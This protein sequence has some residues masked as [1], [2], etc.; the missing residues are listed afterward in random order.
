MIGPCAKQVVTATII[1]PDGTRFVG[2]NFCHAAQP[3]CPRAGMATG[4]RYDLCGSIC[5]QSGHAE[6]N[7]LS[8]AGDRAAGAIL[9]IEGHTYA[10]ETC[11][12]ECAAEGIA[13]IVLGPPPQERSAA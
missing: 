12:A 8:L 1:T 3:T 9:Y 10:C 2:T 11:K 7:A 4:E 13:R 5:R 6:I